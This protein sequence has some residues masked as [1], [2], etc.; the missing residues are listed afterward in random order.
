MSSQ[1]LLEA[2]A[3]GTAPG[4]MSFSVDQ[5]HRMIETGI[6]REGEPAELIDGLVLRKDRSAGEESEMIHGPQHAMV[7]TCLSRLLDRAVESL[8]AHVR[9]QLPVTLSKNTEPE[10]DLAVAAG[11]PDDFQDR[12]PGPDSVLAVIEVAESSLTF[13]RTTKQ[14]I[15]AAANIPVY[16]IVNL[17][18]HRLEVFEEPST[19]RQVYAQQSAF[20]PGETVTLPIGTTGEVSLNVA[21]F[22]G[23]ARHA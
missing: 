9:N 20:D 12:H 5:Y 23:R 17:V 13:D 19:E 18:D 6:L 16:W 11:Q 22:L 3:A 21:D 7:L 8:G 1:S 4:V 14:A 10:P 2:A 15:Y